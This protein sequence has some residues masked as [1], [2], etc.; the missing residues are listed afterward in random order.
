MSTD[1]TIP[2][3]ILKAAFSAAGAIEGTSEPGVRAVSIIAKAI[4]DAVMA[5]RERDQWRPI[6]TA[7]KDGARII[8]MWEPFGG[9]SEH[10]ELGKWSVRNGWVNTYGHAFT[11]APT[12]WMPLPVAQKAEG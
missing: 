11:G 4:H 12:H 1:T 2:D 6:A 3:W 9:V 7:P 8:L 10:V 5:E